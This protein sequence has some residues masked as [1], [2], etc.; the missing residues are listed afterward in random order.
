MA[1]L[2]ILSDGISIVVSIVCQD[3]LVP[4]LSAK[5]VGRWVLSP[6]E[7][8][9]AQRSVASTDD[10]NPVGYSY[11]PSYLPDWRCNDGYQRTGV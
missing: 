5:S 4:P 9:L 8:S 3:Q 7:V 1:K 11:K 10:R 6:N 2:G